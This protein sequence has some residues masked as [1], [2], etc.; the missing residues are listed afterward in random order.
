MTLWCAARGLEIN[1]SWLLCFLVKIGTDF[2]WE[3]L[4]LCTFGVHSIMVGSSV[5]SENVLSWSKILVLIFIG[6]CELWMVPFKNIDIRSPSTGRGT[7]VRRGSW[8]KIVLGGVL[9]ITI[10]RGLFF[11]LF[12]CPTG[13][14]GMV[15]CPSTFIV[16]LTWSNHVRIVGGQSGQ[17][18]GHLVLKNEGRCK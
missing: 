17:S 2:V 18:F 1:L 14:S 16:M 5:I 8:E 11:F 9:Q 10:K 4:G 3:I 15:N 12:K 13:L 6:W 7:A